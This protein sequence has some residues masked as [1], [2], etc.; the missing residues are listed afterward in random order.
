M[1]DPVAAPARGADVVE[2]QFLCP[3]I[4]DELGGQPRAFRVRTDGA[5][6]SII[7]IYDGESEIRAL[8]PDFAKL[9][10][11]GN[12]LYVATAPADASQP[13][14]I[15]SRVFVPG[16]GIDEDPVTGSA[17]CTLIP[18]W[19]GRLRRPTLRARQVS[20]RGG[21]L[22]CEHRGERQEAIDDGSDA[23]AGTD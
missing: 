14:D 22:F 18:Y 16:G 1:L 17:H 13:Y 15:V 5:R 2:G 11:R 12:L 19:A 10:A 9:A 20:P 8:T 4:G 6:D 7:A 3:P 23:A 21:E